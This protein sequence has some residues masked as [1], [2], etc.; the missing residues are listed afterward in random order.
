MA[1]LL[2]CGN[3]FDGVSDTLLSRTEIL[4]VNGVIA[5]VAPSVARPSMVEVIDLTRLTVMPQPL[6]SGPLPGR[7]ESRELFMM[8]ESGIA[9]ARV[10]LAATSASAELMG[11][12]DIGVLAPGKRANLIGVVGDPF[13]DISVVG[14]PGFV[15]LDGRIVRR[16][17]RRLDLRT[18]DHP[19]RRSRDR[20]VLRARDIV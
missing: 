2:V 1:T 15:M 12:T 19:E 6:I 18:G 20:L 16:P 10:L 17:S 8:V 7:G 3:V 11:R 4:I 9:A 13:E 14:K 5:D